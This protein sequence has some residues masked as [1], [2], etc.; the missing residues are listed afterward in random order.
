MDA[1]DAAWV[2]DRLKEFPG[3]Q[4]RVEFLD[5]GF[6][7]EV[8]E[9]DYDFFDALVRVDAAPSADIALSELIHQWRKHHASRPDVYARM[10]DE[11]TR[12]ELDAELKRQRQSIIAK[13]VQ[14]AALAASDIISAGPKRV[15]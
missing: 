2:S 15:P 1:M 6:M 12:S 3:L 10:E 8:G 5:S 7:A 4:I 13:S 14:Q 11:I 9:E